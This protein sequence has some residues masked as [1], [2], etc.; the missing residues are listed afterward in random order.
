MDEMIALR[1]K[2]CG[3]PLDKKDLES[4]SPFVTCQSCGTTQQRMDAKAYLDQMMGQIQTWISKSIP[5]GFSMAQ[6]E[7]VDSVA[8]YN[9]FVTN[10]KPK[11]ETEYSEY[12]FAIN[13]LLSNPLIVL[14]FTTDASI[15]ACHESNQAFEFNAK[16]KSIEALAVDNNSMS[17]VKGAENIATAYALLINNTKLL[18]EDKPGRYILLSNN[19]TEAAKSFASIKGYELASQR[20]E[21]LAIIC[22]GCEKLLN[23]DVMSA[24]PMFENGQTK[25][26]GIKDKVLSDMNLGIMYQAVD[27]EIS[28]TKILADIAG[29]VTNGVSDDPLVVLNV[30]RKVFGFKFTKSGD[31]GYLLG[32]KDRYNEIFSYISA[33]MKAKNGGSLPIVSGSGQVLVPFWDV[34]LRYSFQTGAMWKKKS[35]E[36]VEDILLP[37]D[38]V[39]D[40]ACLSDPASAL[41]DIFALRPEKSILS[42]IKGTETSISGGEGISKISLFAENT[43]GGRK[44]VVPLSTKREAEKLV[45]DY[46]K[47]RTSSDS[48]LK[49]SKPYVKGLIYI[50]CE[51]DSNLKVPAGFGSLV[52]KRIKRTNVSDLIIV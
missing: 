22:N 26:S 45:S 27:M 3:A 4:D 25:L 38:F 19:F 39:I 15:K 34:D 40:D 5:G 21:A 31:W 1:C 7:N 41:T 50:P 13:T 20:F 28:Q 23:G 46:L 33:I 18:H 2:H 24:M 10:I 42:G 37:A 36:V 32:N 29:F 17:L 48:Q 9:I 51:V 14:P 52:P 8:R 6:S 44:V 16:A 49:L 12:R 11:I 30:I 35:V 43:P 47:Q